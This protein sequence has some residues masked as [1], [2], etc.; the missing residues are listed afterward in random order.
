MII[1]LNFYQI[2]NYHKLNEKSIKS[3]FPRINSLQDKSFSSWRIVMPRGPIKWPIGFEPLK[4]NLKK[5]WIKKRIWISQ[6]I[7]KNWKKK[8]FQK[9]CGEKKFIFDLKKFNLFIFSFKIFFQTHHFQSKTPKIIKKKT[10]L[11]HSSGK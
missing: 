11:R 3:P 10:D 4:L 6:K 1:N 2:E 7:L 8:V 9:I 5:P